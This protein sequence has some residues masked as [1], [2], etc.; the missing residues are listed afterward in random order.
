MERERAIGGGQ[1]PKSG[2]TKYSLLPPLE[3]A[4]PNGNEIKS[5]NPRN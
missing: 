2:A 3:Q 1:C 4:T 5:D